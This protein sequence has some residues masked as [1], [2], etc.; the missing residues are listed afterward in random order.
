MKQ[1]QRLLI[2]QLRD[3]L[4]SHQ[5]DKINLAEICK[6]LG[7]QLTDITRWAPTPD[8]LIKQILDFKNLVISEVLD[9][10]KYESESAIDSMV[11]S[12]Q[13][14]YERFGQLSPAKYVFIAK[15]NPELYHSY[16]NQIIDFIEK[17]LSDN[18]EK[19]I[20][21]GEY[22][23]DLNKTKIIGKYID[24]IKA[25]HSQDYLKSEHFT[26]AN[27]FSNIFEDYLQEVA[28]EENWN[29]FRKRKQFYEAI[30]FANR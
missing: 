28:T 4:H 6:A 19:G 16:Q 1:D 29:Y 13:E 21:N 24:R 11:I 20:L 3:Y 5:S 17:R 8:S 9:F 14:I 25:I 2:I 12:G 15:M 10:E 18:L 7:Y 30:S 23:N 22:K 27:I 26:F